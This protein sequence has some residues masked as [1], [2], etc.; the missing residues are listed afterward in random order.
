MVWRI[1]L[2][3]FSASQKSQLSGDIPQASSVLFSTTFCGSNRT[4]AER[5]EFD[6]QRPSLSWWRIRMTTT[7]LEWEWVLQE[8]SR[9]S[10]I[11]KELLLLQSVKVQNRFVDT[12]CTKFWGF[13]YACWCQPFLELLL[14][15]IQIFQ[16]LAAVLLWGHSSVFSK[17]LEINWRILSTN[18]C[19]APHKVSP[20]F[21]SV[22]QLSFYRAKI[23]KNGSRKYSESTMVT[24]EIKLFLHFQ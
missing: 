10:R 3:V 13:S 4:E 12:S 19:Q 23:I 6:F 15:E 1:V 18:K 24:R 20:L 11:G 2:A 22:S 14:L 21:S 7:A 16:N 5:E 9:E 8:S 17:L